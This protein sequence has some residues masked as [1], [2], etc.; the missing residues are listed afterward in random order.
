MRLLMMKLNL[1]HEILEPLC[2]ELGERCALILQK[3]VRKH[4][5]V[6]FPSK[7]VK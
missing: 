6:K 2:K 3:H 5:H 1:H 4:E 7:T